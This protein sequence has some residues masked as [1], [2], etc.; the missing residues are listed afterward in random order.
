M[1]SKLRSHVHQ[2][3][4][5]YIALFFALTGV[6]YAAGPL[7]AGDPAGGDL[8]GTYPNPSIAGSAVNS[9]KTE[10]NSLTG[11]DILESSLGQVPSAADADSL[12]GTAASSYLKSGDSAGGGLTGN[13]P[14][15]QLAPQEAWRE[16]GASGQPPFGQC[17]SFVSTR[18]WANAIFEE[19]STTAFFRDAFGIVHLKGH[20][21]CSPPPIDATRFGEIFVLPAGY[22]PARSETFATTTGSF[23]PISFNAIAV[24][25]GGG[26]FALS[27]SNVQNGISLDGITFRCEPS[28]SNG[29]P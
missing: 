18:T 6:A 27:D 8:T 15:P 28:G 20:P 4:V 21:T 17:D 25:S 5:G 29:C 16:V 13:Y 12:G 19:V 3:V 7:K 2:N 23:Q 14:N 26:V 10:N 9:V 11:D 24:A 1:L 22:R